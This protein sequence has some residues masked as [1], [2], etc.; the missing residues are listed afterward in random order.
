MWKDLCRFEKTH[1]SESLIGDSTLD[2]SVLG[3]TSVSQF[4]W[5]DRDSGHGRQLDAIMVL[6]VSLRCHTCD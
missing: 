2:H 6:R 1:S 4:I 5:S 3:I